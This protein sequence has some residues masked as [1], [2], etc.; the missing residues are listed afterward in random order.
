M[1]LT[2]ERKLMPKGIA[3]DPANDRRRH[4][5]SGGRPR[6]TPEGSPTFCIRVPVSLH[7]ALTATEPDEIRRVLAEA[8][9][10][11]LDAE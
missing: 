9:T 7:A 2:E 11:P 8:F 1:F 5:K 10:V 4:T 6:K 3:K